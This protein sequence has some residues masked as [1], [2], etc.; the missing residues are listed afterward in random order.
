PASTLFPYTTLFRSDYGAQGIADV[1]ESVALVQSGPNP[2]LSLLGFLLTM[3]APRRTVHQLYEERLRA[4]YGV[5]V[6]GAK[7][8]EAVDK[9]RSEEHTSEL[10]S[11]LN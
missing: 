3:V 1:Q 7:V 10:Q 5:A 9:N 4:L 11:H 8:P 2:G 6:F